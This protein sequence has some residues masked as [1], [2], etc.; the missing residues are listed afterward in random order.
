MAQL[1]GM[2]LDPT[3]WAIPGWEKDLRIRLWWMLAMHDAWMSFCE[4]PPCGCLILVNSRPALIQ[5]NNNSV[6]FPSF[7]SLLEAS[8]A[9]TP[10]STDSAKSFIASCKLALLVR[11]L[12]STVCTIG[13]TENQDTV[14][15]KDHVL[16]IAD[17]VDQLY[18]DWKEQATG[19]RSRP[20]GV[21]E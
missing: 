18:D 3:R 11:R 8:C 15:R 12:Q 1:L 4:C 10:A 2:H 13:I 17:K 9:Y 20:T 16:A 7:S 19:T 21:S 14:Q 5:A 6:P